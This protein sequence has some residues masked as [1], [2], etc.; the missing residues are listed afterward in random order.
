MCSHFHSIVIARPKAVA[1]QEVST[2]KRIAARAE[3]LGC[4][5]V[6]PRNDDT[7]KFQ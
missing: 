6:P 7:E 5:V 4:F 3:F 2:M 1:N